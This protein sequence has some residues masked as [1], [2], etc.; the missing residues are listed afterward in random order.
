MNLLSPDY[1]RERIPFH[2]LPNETDLS[3]EQITNL[4]LDNL[5]SATGK[6]ITELY[7]DIIHGYLH[8]SFELQYCN[9]R[10]HTVH[11]KKYNSRYILMEKDLLFRLI[12]QF[13]LIVSLTD[14][15]LGKESRFEGIAYCL[16]LFRDRPLFQFL[17]YLKAD[18][19]EKTLLMETIRI[20]LNDIHRKNFFDVARYLPSSIKAKLILDAIQGNTALERGNLI[21]FDIEE[22][23]HYLVRIQ[24]FLPDLLR[25]Q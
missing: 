21:R 10:R 2:A 25:Q 13:D 16:N 17:D 7:P 1:I 3:E 23:N 4:F 6:G 14:R 20:G 18:I 9:S 12:S 8:N 24:P 11:V 22:C 5:T 15:I 19:Y